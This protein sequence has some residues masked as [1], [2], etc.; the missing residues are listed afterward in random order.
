MPRGTF[1]R[2]EWNSNLSL[3]LTYQPRWMEGLRL[4]ADVLNVMN[5]RSVTS[6]NETCETAS[7]TFL[8]GCHQPLS[9]TR[10]REF[11]FTAEYDF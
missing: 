10:A 5:D 9:A 7:N 1:G 4:S 11:R 8:A 6:V 3:N 2:L